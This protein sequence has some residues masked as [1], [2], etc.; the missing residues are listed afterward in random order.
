MLD[1]ALEV[2]ASDTGSL[3]R[4]HPAG[5]VGSRRFSLMPF[6]ILPAF[7]CSSSQGVVMGV[8]RCGSSQGVFAMSARRA[9]M[10]VSREPEATDT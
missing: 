5:G 10:Q 2:R 4:S 7:L 3:L 9:C 8:V 1:L 6:L